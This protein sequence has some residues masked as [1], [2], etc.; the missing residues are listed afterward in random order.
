MNAFHDINDRDQMACRN[1]PSTVNLL[2]QS[3]YGI[4]TLKILNFRPGMRLRGDKPDFVILYR[5]LNPVPIAT[6]FNFFI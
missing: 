6:W 3:L 2:F 4:C 5:K 1:R